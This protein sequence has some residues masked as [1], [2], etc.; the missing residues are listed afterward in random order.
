MGISP[1]RPRPKKVFTPDSKL[2]AFQ[3]I[4]AIPSGGVME[5]KRTLIEGSPEK[6]AE[7]IVR[8]LVERGIIGY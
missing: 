3:R 7:R 8:F 4:D 5:R 6:L 2:S 1:P